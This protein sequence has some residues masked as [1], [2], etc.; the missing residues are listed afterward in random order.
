MAAPPRAMRHTA[1]CCESQL[2]R[3]SPRDGSWPLREANSPQGSL[4]RYLDWDAPLLPLAAG[5]APFRPVRDLTQDT[6]RGAER[7]SRRYSDGVIPL[8]RKKRRLKLARL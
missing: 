1:Q 3:G 2:D 5:S 6:A 8:K 4:C 7:A